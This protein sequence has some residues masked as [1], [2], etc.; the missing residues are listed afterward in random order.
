MCLSSKAIIL[1]HGKAIRLYG[2]D[3]GILKPNELDG[4]PDYVLFAA[5]K[6]NFDEIETCCLVAYQLAKGHFFL[7]G[8]KRT[9]TQVL[10][11]CI[12]M[13]GYK[14]TGREIDLVYK[15]EEISRS[16]PKNK[17]EEVKSFAYFIKGHLQKRSAG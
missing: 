7:D 15:I 6:Y 1:F 14:Y 3:D 16:N 5:E 10:Y 11:A 12:K 4:L 9:A 8:N 2:G 17:E 13:C